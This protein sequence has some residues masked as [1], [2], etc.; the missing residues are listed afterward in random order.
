MYKIIILLLKRL[1][2]NNPQ[3][4]IKIEIQ[5]M[6]LF[7]DNSR[8]LRKY[9]KRKLFYVYH[10][11]ISNMSK[12]DETVEFIHPISVVIGSRAI[13][14]KNCVIYQDVTIGSDF[15]SDNQMPY[16]K[17]NTKIGAGAKLI[18]DIV[19]GRN[20]IVGANSVITKNIP[21]NSIAYGVNQFRKNPHV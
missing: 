19:I 5:L 17:E 7:N 12:I 4:R 9:F 3:K 11:D 1:T 14:E 18:G 6:Y 2:T 13:V 10:C 21:D 16:I 20:C 15:Y 8:Y